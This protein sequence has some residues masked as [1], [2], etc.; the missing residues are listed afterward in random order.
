[1]AEEL[2]KFKSSPHYERC[3]ELLSPDFIDR[4]VDA[5]SAQHASR[6]IHSGQVLLGPR[7]PLFRKAINEIAK[8]VDWTV[9]KKLLPARDY[10]AKLTDLHRAIMQDAFG[11][12]RPHLPGEVWESLKQLFETAFSKAR[13]R[14]GLK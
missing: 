8:S 11:L 14:E 9:S 3:K 13:L 5:G 10:D 6:C 7:D 4:I 12:I 2:E 1:M